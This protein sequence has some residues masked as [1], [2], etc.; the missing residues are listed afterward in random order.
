MKTLLV[1]GGSGKLVKQIIKYNTKY[2]IF[3]PS[4]NEMDVSDYNSVD[5]YIKSCNPDIFLHSGA[6]T[7]PMQKH[8]DN[9]DL[10]IKNNIIGT[11]NVVLACIE[12]NI[13][14]VYISTDYVYPG[15]SGPY[16]EDDPLKPFTKYGWSKLGGECAVQLYDNSLI[17]RACICDY[18]FPHPNAFTDVTKN[19]MYNMDVS[20][21]ILNLLDEYGIV[22]V[23]GE[24]QT[25]YEFVKEYNPD[26]GKISTSDLPSDSEITKKDTSMCI[27]KMKGLL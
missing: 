6:Y 5:E 20:K 21:I 19:T 12:H 23:G 4:R 25:M 11:S 13:K 17:L 27:K 8:V 3:A 16:Q 18:P 22:N 15:I 7:R 10:S 24:P 2:Q 26:I 9:P 14:L 1:S